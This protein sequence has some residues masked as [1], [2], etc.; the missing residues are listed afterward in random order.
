[1]VT[2][3]ADLTDPPKVSSSDMSGTV[4]MWIGY[5]VVAGMAFVALGLAQNLIAPT[6]GNLLGMVGLQSGE[7]GVTVS[8][9]GGG[10]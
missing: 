6:V 3:N 2:F 7:G 8:T 5:V 10:L 9:S 1:M 4:K